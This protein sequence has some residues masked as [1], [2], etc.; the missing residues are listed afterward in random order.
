MKNDFKKY[1]K[2]TS[3]EASAFYN[4]QSFEINDES[5]LFNYNGQYNP[6]DEN[7]TSHMIDTYKKSF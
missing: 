4:Q 1:P 3:A 7:S 5:K 6:L 2:T